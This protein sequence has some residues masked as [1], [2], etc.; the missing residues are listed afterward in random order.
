MNKSVI[1][2]KQNESK[3][4]PYLQGEDEAGEKDKRAKL[5][6]ERSDLLGRISQLKPLLS[7]AQD[8]VN[9][10][11]K[12]KDIGKVESGHV[13]LEEANGRPLNILKRMEEVDSTLMQHK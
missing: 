6:E 7:S 9:L 3:T 2:N 12:N 11:V 4:P 5:I 8:L 13:L 1:R 10:G